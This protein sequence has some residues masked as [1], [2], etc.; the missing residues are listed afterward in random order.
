MDSQIFAI[1]RQ[2]DAEA[3]K[4][5]RAE[6]MAEHAEH[7]GQHFSRNR[8]DLEELSWDMFNQAFADVVGGYWSTP[9]AQDLAATLVEIKTVGQF[10][11]DYIEEDLRGMKAYTQGKGGQIH[12][13]IIRAQRE[14]MPREELVAALDM[15]QD[16]V[17]SN[18]WGM[19]TKLQAQIAE[20]MRTRPSIELLKMVQQAIQTGPTFGSFAAASLSDTQLDPVLNA[21]AERS[22]GLAT[23]VGTL[24]AIRK[25]ANVGLDFG[26]AMQDRIFQTGVIAQYKGYPVVQLA[27]WED[28]QG[29]FEIPNNEL[30]ILGKNCGRITYYGNTVK[31]QVLQ[32]P[33]FYLRWEWARDLGISVYGASKGRMGRVVLT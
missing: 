2:V 20:Q 23:I 3:D 22:G 30:Y 32:R 6:L 24:S 28:F 25:L 9:G 31:S 27:N 33:S 26:P 5:K 21:V 13:Y 29:A 15:H 11:T 18:F 14:Q 19:L 7:L 1:L 8:A 16:E 10:E 12:S 4:V 17:A